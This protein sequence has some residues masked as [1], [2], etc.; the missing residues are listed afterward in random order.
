MVALQ[1]TTRTVPIIFVTIIDP[2]GAGYEDDVRGKR[3]QL[4]RISAGV[5]GVCAPSS[6]DAAV[7][8]VRPA[9]LSQR[10]YKRRVAGLSFRIV[11][12]RI[13]EDADAPHALSL[14]SPRRARPCSG[15]TTEQSEKFA[16]PHWSG[17][18]HR[19]DEL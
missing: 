18:R 15:G 2:V 19:N 9:E 5:A 14:L 13:H 4:C 11:R 1:Q 8:V 12:G 3:D 6:L 10:L 7:A 17:L 16:P